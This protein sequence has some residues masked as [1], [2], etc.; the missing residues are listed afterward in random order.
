MEGTLIR[1]TGFET[2]RM[3]ALSDGIFAVALTLLVLELKP[4]EPAHTLTENLRATLPKLEAWLISFT[5]AGVFWILHHNLFAVLRRVNTAFNYF[6][7]LLMMCVSLIPWSSALLG[8]YNHDPGAVV[9]FSG[10][11]GVIGLVMLAQ[12][13]YA[14]GRADLTSPEI[15]ANARL[16]ITLLLVRLPFVALLSISLAFVNRTA[17]LWVWLLMILAG[18]AMRERYARTYA[19]ILDAASVPLP[20][21]AEGDIA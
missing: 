4:D 21:K 14:S 13:L 10:I 20:E 12:W 3:S 6:N 16:L 19:T 15:N 17:A 11:M 18:I 5:V 2:A 8:T 7:L 9:L 1:K